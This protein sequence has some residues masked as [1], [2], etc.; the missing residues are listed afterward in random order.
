MKA[1]AEGKENLA[2]P[3]KAKNHLQGKSNIEPRQ[4]KICGK[5]STSITWDVAG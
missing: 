3:V 4:R 5:S 2:P 1:K